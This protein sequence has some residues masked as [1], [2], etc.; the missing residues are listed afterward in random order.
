MAVGF[1]QALVLL[2]SKVL[3]LGHAGGTVVKD[4][5]FNGLLAYKL[6]NLLCNA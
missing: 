2:Y 1:F 6:H 4:L 5:H 3:D